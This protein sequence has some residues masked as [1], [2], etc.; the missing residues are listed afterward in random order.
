MAPSAPGITAITAPLKAAQTLSP[1]GGIS[2]SQAQPSHRIEMHVATQAK[3]II[4]FLYQKTL[5][6]PL[7]QMAARPMPP[8]EVHRVRNQQPMH[9]APQIWPTRLGDQVKMV[10]H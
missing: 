1:F 8:I 9:P 7:K 6:S 2:P 4:A 5:I 3:Q 10:A